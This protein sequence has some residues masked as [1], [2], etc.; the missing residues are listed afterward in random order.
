M[1]SNHAVDDRF[2]ALAAFS[3][4]QPAD[5]NLEFSNIGM[6][7]AADSILKRLVLRSLELQEK[8]FKLR[9][10]GVERGSD[11]LQSLGLI[12]GVRI[13]D[14]KF[15]AHESLETGVTRRISGRRR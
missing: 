10:A 8:I 14:G 9:P 4:L 3:R 5:E 6:A 2:V 11:Q 1:G 7:K 15:S 12:L 13:S